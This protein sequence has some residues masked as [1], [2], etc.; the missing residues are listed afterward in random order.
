LG[1]AALVHADEDVGQDELLHLELGELLSVPL[2]EIAARRPQSQYQAPALVTVLEREDIER[3]SVDSIPEVLRRVPG[4][5]VMQTNA[6][7]YH[8]GLRGLNQLENNRVLVLIDGRVMRNLST[9]AVTWTALPISLEDVERI[10]ILH[11]PGALLYG[12]NALNGVIHI[13][14]RRPLA[15]TS[16]A[17]ASS[18]VSASARSGLYMLEVGDPDV[19]K[20]WRIDNGS[21]AHAAWSWANRRR[22]FGVRTSFG[23]GGLPMWQQPNALTDQSGFFNYHVR[24]TADYM[25]TPRTDVRLSLSHQQSEAPES[26]ST[27]TEVRAYRHRTQAFNFHLHQD[28]PFDGLSTDLQ[29]D[30]QRRKDRS[31]GDLLTS[32]PRE[33]YL[34]GMSLWHLRLG[35]GLDTLSFGAEG[36]AQS[37]I[38]FRSSEPFGL[39]GAVLGQNE[40]RLWRAPLVLLTLGLRAEQVRFKQRAIEATYRQLNPSGALV[41]DFDQR[42]NLRL[43]AATGRRNPSGFEMFADFDRF[44][45]GP[46]AA[47]FR[48][49]VPNPSLKPTQAL[50]LE[51]GYAGLV[52]PQL[53]LF[54]NVYAQRVRDLEGL[55]TQVELPLQFVNLRDVDMLGSEL[56]GTFAWNARSRVWAHY[57]FN[58]SRDVDTQQKLRDWPSHL[59][60]VGSEL[61]ISRTLRVASELSAWAAIRPDVLIREGELTTRAGRVA[62]QAIW[63]VHLGHSI[64]SGSGELFV[65]GRNLGSLFR[66]VDDTRQYVSTRVEPIGASVVLGLQITEKL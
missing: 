12:P 54:A 16:D 41:V 17:G 58:Y 6:G 42:H 49:L 30:G 22:D 26:V 9:E 43:V 14:T 33:H 61:A 40:L 18:V 38:N 62:P 13:R 65:A 64:L 2:V 29:L 28:L 20:P 8:V 47:P 19:D 37:T 5:F 57:A 56:G 23:V 55:S 32:D 50:S 39:Y 44:L 25:P 1:V 60:Q 48:P 59:G 3:M 45:Y 7:V 35:E 11:G 21:S 4:A 52:R 63:N 27:L 24:A 53:R 66:D 34:R 10:E 51:L 15:E 46:D 31:S 36:F